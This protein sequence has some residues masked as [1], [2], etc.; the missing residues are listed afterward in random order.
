[1]AGAEP[2]EALALGRQGS[3]QS[4]GKLGIV[5]RDYAEAGLQLTNLYFGVGQFQ[6][7]CLH[8]SFL[9]AYFLRAFRISQEGALLNP[10]K[11]GERPCTSGLSGSGSSGSG[12]QTSW[13]P[14]FTW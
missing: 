11:T 2:I 9:P 7:D 13:S 8:V 14:S 12:T 5:H 3:L 6:I 1:V 10:C 4:L